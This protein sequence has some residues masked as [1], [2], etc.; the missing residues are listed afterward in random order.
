MPRIYFS[1][2]DQQKAE[3]LKGL[4]PQIVA[5]IGR[6][7]GTFEFYINVDREKSETAKAFILRTGE[8][9]SKKLDIRLAEFIESNAG[10]DAEVVMVDENNWLSKE[11]VKKIVEEV[12]GYC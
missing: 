9:V 1:V 6:P 12:D 4:I 10:V 11:D 8:R 2:K 5:F 7:P 3:K